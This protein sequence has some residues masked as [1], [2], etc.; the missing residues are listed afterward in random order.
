MQSSLK[1]SFS[2]ACAKEV[3]KL[4]IIESIFGYKKSASLVG[5]T[6]CFPLR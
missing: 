6:D 3:V 1:F 4:S 5:I 2:A